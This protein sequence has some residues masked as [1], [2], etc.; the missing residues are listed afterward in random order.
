MMDRKFF[1]PAEFKLDESGAIRVAFAQLNVTDHDGDILEPGVMPTKD[2]VMGAYGHT[3]WD[4]IL[5]TGKG[6]IREEDEWA[7]LSGQFNLD[8]TIGRDTYSTVKFLGPLQEWSY[9]Y[10]ATNPRYETRDGKQV[11]I[12]TPGGLDVF[13]VSPVLKGAGVDTHTMAIKSGGLDPDLPFADHTAWI[14]GHVKAYLDRFDDRAEL[15]TKEGGPMAGATLEE[16][17]AMDD[18]LMTVHGRMRDLMAANQPPKAL[19]PELLEQALAAMGRGN[20]IPI[21]L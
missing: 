6:T 21:T 1:T 5:P 9:G 18:M 4:G 3:V 11:R 10:K 19:D 20:G 8:S 14:L 15:R 2:V 17:A 13:E 7:V 16:L 12:F